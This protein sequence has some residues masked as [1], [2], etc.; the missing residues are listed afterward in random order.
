MVARPFTALAPGQGWFRAIDVDAP[1]ETVF[2]WVTQLRVAP[3]SYDW[4]D[5]I[6]RRSPQ[7]L[8]LSLLDL[9]VGD[10]AMRFFTVTAVVP[11]TSMTLGLNGG[12]RPGLLG[13]MTVHYGVDKVGD[14]ARLTVQLVVPP[15]R[16]PFK[17]LR[18]YV[19][20][21]GDLVMMRKQLM[22]LKRL[23]ETTA[24]NS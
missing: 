20:A 23:A 9:R 13:R 11:G 1:A 24:A 6:G 18:R 15:A 2:A 3:H 10:S 5:N 14:G 12:S 22:E 4:L 7:T 21:W 16:G 17:G 19:L 8:D